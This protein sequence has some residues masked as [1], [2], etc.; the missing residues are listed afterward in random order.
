MKK[1][2]PIISVLGFIF[3]L[4]LTGQN[5]IPNTRPAIAKQ[6]DALLDSAD[7]YHHK[8]LDSALE[9]SLRARELASENNYIEG[10]VNGLTKAALNLTFKGEP[11]KMQEIYNQ[12]IYSS[13]NLKDKSA[14]INTYFAMGESFR[15]LHHFDKSYYYFQLGI[16][17]IFENPN[18]Q[19]DNNMAYL[20]KN[21]GY[22]LFYELRDSSVSI[23]YL[24]KAKDLYLNIG[25]NHEYLDMYL[26]IGNSY[27]LNNDFTNT[28]L[29]FDSCKA[30]LNYNYDVLIDA[31]YNKLVGA[32][33]LDNHNMAIGIDY[34]NKSIELYNSVRDKKQLGDVYTMLAYAYSN[35]DDFERC[36][37]YNMLARDSRASLGAITVLTSSMANLSGNYFNIG[38][39]EKALLFADSAYI[40]ASQCDHKFYMYKGALQFFRIYK[41]IGKTLE[42]LNYLELADSINNILIAQ[43]KPS[44][45][46][47]ESKIKLQ[48][49]ESME[50]S[51]LKIE[52]TRN[53]L[54]YS[55]YI[56]LFLLFVIILFVFWIFK[57]KRTLY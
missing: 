13:R 52:K 11:V 34:L 39:Y 26:N 45:Q 6:V 10:E 54:E 32:L 50:N 48:N 25:N 56:S 51:K 15:S 8:S 43:K 12:A 22:L 37:E 33:Y 24:R 16:D 9:F 42:A 27:R 49:K 3:I 28:R 29:Y 14:L 38:Q 7:F 47:I 2:I 19:T 30:L 18:C 40:F 1:S 41:K 20:Y 57:L 44:Y 55:I 21:L 4:A 36:I 46:L 23:D 31:M 35:M 17:L 53:Q 5:T